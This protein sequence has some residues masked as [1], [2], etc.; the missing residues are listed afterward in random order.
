MTLPFPRAAPGP[1]FRFAVADADHD[2][3]AMGPT[4]RLHV[5][6]SETTGTRVHA[7]ALR[8]QIRIEPS[9]RRY[10][11]EEQDHLVELFGEPSRWGRTLNPMQLATVSTVTPSFTGETA[12]TFEVPL[13]FDTEIAATRYFR[14]LEAGEVPLLLLFSGTVFYDSEAGVQIGLV[15]WHA[16]ATHRLPIRVWQDMMAAHYGGTAWLQVPAGTLEKLSAWRSARA[17]PNWEQTF[18]ALLD[19]A[20]EPGS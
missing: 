5:T 14:G 10:S 8:A 9:Q 15:P 6:V 1:A 12:V 13:T 16:E 20:G 4:L 18:D 17:L 2:M 19:A 11:G 3:H 7:L